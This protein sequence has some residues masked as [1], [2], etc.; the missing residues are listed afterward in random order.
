MATLEYF[1]TPNPP[2]CPKIRH[3][4]ESF[5]SHV[6]SRVGS[7]R[8]KSRGCDCGGNTVANAFESMGAGVALILKGAPDEQVDLISSG[9][10][11]A[12]DA[13]ARGRSQIQGA[14]GSAA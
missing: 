9:R 6:L 11:R 7:S 3:L 5:P 8:L 10:R 2:L 4:P 14:A 1:Q 12:R 13:G